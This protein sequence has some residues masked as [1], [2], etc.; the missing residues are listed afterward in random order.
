VSVERPVVGRYRVAAQ[1]TRDRGWRPAQLDSDLP[2]AQP[3]EPQ[4]SDL[5]PLILRQIPGA[6]LAHG[7]PVKRR[8]EPGHLAIAVDLVTA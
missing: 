3:R 5:D 6:D 2:D 8:H 4:I 7:Q 1:L